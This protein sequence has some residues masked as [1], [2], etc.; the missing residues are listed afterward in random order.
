RPMSNRAYGLHWMVVLGVF[1]ATLLGAILA[2]PGRAAILVT[3]TSDGGPGSLRDAILGANATPGADVITL[4]A[5]TYT[6]T[7]AGAD[8]DAGATGDLDITDDLTINGAGAAT[9]IIDGS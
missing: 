5:G 9:T 3:T 7:I 1:V 8:E 4:P 6:L 2:Q